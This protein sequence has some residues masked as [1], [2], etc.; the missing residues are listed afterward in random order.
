MQQASEMHATKAATAT[1][2]K[3]NAQ[4]NIFHSQLTFKGFIVWH[5]C[6]CVYM[7]VCVSVNWKCNDAEIQHSTCRCCNYHIQQKDLTAPFLPISSPFLPTLCVCVR[8]ENEQPPVRPNSAGMQSEGGLE[9]YQRGGGQCPFSVASGNFH[10]A[11]FA[12]SL[13]SW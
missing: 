3:C 5:A 4:T 12:P 13:H 2:T 10:T 9:T 7:S 11:Q 8:S 6:V 1:N